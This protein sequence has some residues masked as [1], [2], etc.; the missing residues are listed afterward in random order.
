MRFEGRKGNELIRKLVISLVALV[1]LAH[2]ISVPKQ[3][4]ADDSFVTMAELKAYEEKKA[5]QE[6]SNQLV[7][8]SK[9]LV[10]KRTGQCVMAVRNYFGISKNDVQGQARSTKPNSK[11]PKVGSVIVLNM[12]KVGHVGIVIAVDGELVTYFDSNGN[13]TQRGAIRTIIKS[14]RRIIGYRITK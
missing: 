1:T 14:D 3:V 8:Y 12:S 13:W 6:W 5:E 10:G 11:D 9:T 7:A 4:I 2:L